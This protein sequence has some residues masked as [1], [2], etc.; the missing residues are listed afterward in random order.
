MSRSIRG[1]FM[2]LGEI[3]AL[4]FGF[5]GLPPMMLQRSRYAVDFLTHQLRSSAATD[6]GPTNKTSTDFSLPDIAYF[7]LQNTLGLSE[8]VM[9]RVCFHS[10]SILGMTP[11]NLDN[12]VS[13]LKRMMNLSDDDV[14]VMVTKQP[15]ILQYSAQRNL[16][17][18]ILL[19]VRSL[20]LSKEELRTLLLDSPSILGYSLSNLKRKI[21]FFFNLY[22]G[23]DGVDSDSVRKL[24]LST[25]KVMLA[26]VDTG[27]R[28]R[29]DFLHREMQF[30]Q[31]ELQRLFLKNPL[32]LLYSV[33]ENIKNKIVFFFILQLN[34]EP[35]DVRK[36][37]LKF[38]QVVD[39]SLESHLR[40]LF[41]FFTLDIKFSAAEFGVIVLKF[42]KLFSYSLFKAKHVTGY[43]RYEL[44]LNAR[45]TKRVLFQAPQV[46]GLS[47]LKLKQKLEFL[48][49][50]LN[51]GP[52]E[53]NAIFSKM[54]TVVCVGLSNISCKLDYME[55]ILKQEG[56]LSSLRDVVLK[57]PTL[58][59]YSHHSRIVPRMQMLV[60]NMVDPA[61][62]SVCI[63][64]SESNFVKWL[65]RSTARLLAKDVDRAAW[66]KELADNLQII[67]SEEMEDVLANHP[68]LAIPS[69]QKRSKQRLLKMRRARLFPRD[70]LE[71]LGYEDEKFHDLISS[72]LL[73]SFLNEE[74][75]MNST[76]TEEVLVPVLKLGVNPGKKSCRNRIKSIRDGVNS[77]DELVCILLQYPEALSGDKIEFNRFLATVLFQYELESKLGMSQ[78]EEERL[79]ITSVELQHLLPREPWSR[80]AFRL[81]ILATIDCILSQTN[82]DKAA[83]TGWRLIREQPRL[84]LVPLSKLKTRFDLMRETECD[85]SVISDI[86]FMPMADAKQFCAMHYLRHK[87]RFTPRVLQKVSA[88]SSLDVIMSIA[89]CL[90]SILPRDTVRSM[91]LESPSLLTKGTTRKICQRVRLLCHLDSVGLPYKPDNF[92]DFLLQPNQAFVKEL[93][94][95][96]E[97]WI[98]INSDKEASK[99]ILDDFP[100]SVPYVSFQEANRAL[101]RVV[102]WN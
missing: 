13:L 74:M 60:K 73:R 38:P 78:E 39:Y 87:L 23:P 41:E 71:A 31:D 49:S 54:P 12:K 21:S 24:L 18:T 22:D 93:V 34:L 11:R 69:Q 40:P 46:L 67:D 25:P 8:E 65:D 88:T 47:E 10:G 94:P 101:S 33:E 86:A 100:R 17:P 95:N 52:E 62:I 30:S 29:V 102:Q 66:V 92:S 43:L 70:N 51:L 53:L 44:G 37:L 14:R 99:V 4:A 56:S 77:T 64:M 80:R 19:L 72:S 85:V 59:G 76:A 26:G 35:V 50:R 81:K 63:S 5:V 75:K 91:L 96:A 42:P 82:S 20:G 28:P 48:R 83:A 97:T 98:A 45:Q 16:A 89:R 32:I 84:L 79:N 6:I 7:Y 27:L 68:S 61:K 90:E 57:Q 1:H 3:F 36:I 2:I 9:W 58:L 55:M 15:A